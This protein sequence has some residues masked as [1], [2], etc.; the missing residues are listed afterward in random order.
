[1]KKISFITSVLAVL[2]FAANAFAAGIVT[3]NW[4]KNSEPDIAGYNIYYGT[5]SGSY[6]EEMYVDQDTFCADTSCSYQFNSLQEG[7]TWYFV[8]KAVDDG[9]QESVGLSNETSKYIES[10]YTVGGVSISQIFQELG[11]G[12]YR[13]T[14]M[15]NG[16]YEVEPLGN[17]EPV[18]SISA[19]SLEVLESEAVI[20]T[21]SASDPEGDPL[22]YSWYVD[23]TLDFSGD[24]S[25]SW[26]D[27]IVGSHSVYCIIDDGQGNTVQSNTVTIA[28]LQGPHISVPEIL[29]LNATYGDATASGSISV[30]NSGNGDMY[31]NVS[32]TSGM[33][34]I[35]PD[36]G[37]NNWTAGITIDLTGLDPGD[38]YGDFVISSFDADNSPQTV[39]VMVSISDVASN[40]A[41]IDLE[42]GSNQYLSISDA[43]QTGLDIN[44][45]FTIEVRVKFESLDSPAQFFYSHYEAADTFRDF[46]INSGNH[47]VYLSAIDNGV[48]KASMYWSWTPL[49]NVWYRIAIQGPAGGGGTQSDWNFHIEGIDQGNPILEIGN[50]A[51]AW[52]NIGGTINIGRHGSDSYYL[53]GKLDDYR[54]W[55]DLRTTTEI[56]DNCQQELTGT[57]ANLVG[58]WKLDNDL[59]DSTNNGNTLINN[60]SAVF[61]TDIP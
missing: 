40:V 19:N 17:S 55:N 56:L 3:V 32:T 39:P 44:S 21:A 45:D 23:G 48:W 61:S 2:F 1:M 51:N 30:A 6:S 15:A 49:I 7:Q 43:S 41:S 46:Y 54:Q 35:S 25:G 11:S 38:Y 42:S 14:V 27:W 52:Q 33:I 28:V 20:I 8:L 9:G 58:Y 10:S 36:S 13:L 50:F 29:V 24:D 47:R 18:V 16:T 5:S 12:E 31:S 60:N 4:S 34:S 53:D 57:E 26:A 37:I 59:T 22:M